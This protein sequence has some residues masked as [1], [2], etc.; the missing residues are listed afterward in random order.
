M[1]TLP[2]FHDFPAKVDDFVGRQ[3]EMFEVVTNIYN[4]RLVTVIGL[5]GIGKTA[6]AK[7]TLHYLFDRRVFQAG[8]VYIPLK[9]YMNCEIFM[10]KL[11][12]N[13]VIDNFELNTDKEKEI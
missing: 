2:R 10:R 8:I 11:L 13:F 5:P 7:N 4:H 6:L 9:G 3:K 12:V 1:D